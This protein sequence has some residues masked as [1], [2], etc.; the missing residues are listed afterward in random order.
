MMNA[1]QEARQQRGLVI[2]ATLNIRQQG[3]GW[4]V[5]SQTIESRYHVTQEADGLHCSCPDFELRRMPCKH[6]FAV[7]FFLKRE[8]TI[9]PDG[10]T[11][12]TETRA[13]RVTYPQN[14]P[15]YNAAQTAEKELFVHLLRDLT[16]ALPEPEHVNGRPPVPVSDAI[17]SACYK[18]YSSVSS[19]RF[20][21]DL[22][23]AEAQG[24]VTRPWHFN[25]VLKVI[26]NPNLTPTLQR[27]VTACAAPLRSVETAFAIDSTGFG[28]RRFYRHFSAKWGKETASRDWVKLHAL[29]GTKTNVVAAAVVTDRNHHDTLEF[30]PLL[31]KGA[32]HFKITEISA[33]KAYL[34]HANLNAS[35]KIGA[36]PFIPM[37]EGSLDHPKSPAWTKLFHL[38]SYRMDEF[39]PYYHKRSNSESTFSAMKRLFGDTLMSKNTE[40]QVNEL[41]LKVLAY[42]ITCTVHSIFELGV[43]V[44]GISS[45]TQA[46]LNA[47]AI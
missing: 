5:P 24:F 21:T 31:T 46:A 44:P 35:A 29:V 42:N 18:V 11:T 30:V 7:E 45:S 34:S 6:A 22:R 1:D 15:A 25:T 17:F 33:D 32:E 40:A 39:L 36:E 26:E 9:T 2:A 12:V 14:W 37:K 20:M 13:A 28:T 8:T 43:T 23:E 27:L 41:L 10:T 16:A 38:Y 47:H 3:K 19:R 4:S